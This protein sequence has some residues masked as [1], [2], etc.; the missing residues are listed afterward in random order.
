MRIL[1]VGRLVEKKGTDDLLQALA[2]LPGN[3]DWRVRL[4]AVYGE[5]CDIAGVRAEILEA[6]KQDPRFEAEGQKF[7]AQIE[8]KCI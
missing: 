8:K 5:N 4:A 3:L 1:S 7:I 2:R 6:T